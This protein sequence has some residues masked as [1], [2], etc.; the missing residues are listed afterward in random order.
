MIIHGLLRVPVTIFLVLYF[1][2]FLDFALIFRS[3]EPS[4]S[5]RGE[6][7]DWRSQ[8]RFSTFG[9]VF[10]RPFRSSRSLFQVRQVH[11]GPGGPLGAT[12]AIR[13]HLVLQLLSASLDSG[14]KSFGGKK[15]VFTP[16]GR[17]GCFLMF[18]TRG[19]FRVHGFQQSTTVFVVFGRFSIW[20]LLVGQN[21]VL[22]RKCNQKNGIDQLLVSIFMIS[23]HP[24]FGI[25]G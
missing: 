25:V 21:Q 18:N 23:N 3:S 20:A 14:S 13:V 4:R 1:R 22:I 15:L 19:Q 6:C 24:V 8:F 16:G 5:L 10:G 9:Q 12:W 11:L 17:I 2:Q 7:Q